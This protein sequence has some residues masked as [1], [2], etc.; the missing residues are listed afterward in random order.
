MDGFGGEAGLNVGERKMTLVGEELQISIEKGKMLII[1]LM[2]VGPVVE[3]RTLRDVSK[4]MEKYMT[5][6]DHA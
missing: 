3:G 1:R 6:W 5:F 2:T 4:L